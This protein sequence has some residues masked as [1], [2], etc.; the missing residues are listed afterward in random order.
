MQKGPGKGELGQKTKRKLEKE[1]EDI[2]KAV[3]EIKNIKSWP[4]K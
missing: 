2:R 1:Q 4:Q 3:K